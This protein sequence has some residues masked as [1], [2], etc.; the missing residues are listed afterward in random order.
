MGNLLTLHDIFELNK[1][2]F[3]EFDEAHYP[4]DDDAY[5]ATVK[6]VIDNNDEKTGKGHTDKCDTDKDHTDKCDTDKDYT[7]K[8]DTDKPH[9][10]KCDTDKGHTDKDKPH[11][12]KLQV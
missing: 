2:T 3:N 1:I 9:L 11:I 6:Q 4:N 12:N 5:E 7:D 10:N 8:Y